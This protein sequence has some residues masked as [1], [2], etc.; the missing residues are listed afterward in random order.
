[1]ILSLPSF[2]ILGLKM[3]RVVV[4][5]VAL[6]IYFTSGCRS[7]SPAQIAGA[8][9][10]SD[11]ACNAGDQ[12]VFGMAW[13]PV[14]FNTLRALDSAS[15]YAQTLVYEGLLKY[16][17]NLNIVPALASSFSIS[18]DG[19]TYKFQLRKGAK[20]SDGTAITI[21]DVKASFDLAASKA[22]P[23]RSDYKCIESFESLA[24]KE[25]NSFILHL[26]YPSAPLLARLVELRILPARIICAKDR[27]N[28][29]L[30]RTPLGS[31][32]FRLLHWQSG[33]ELVFVPNEFYW[34]EK[35][36]MRQLV[37]R[38]VPDKTLLSIALR[39]GEVDVAAIDPLNL[40][41]LLKTAGAN[42]NYQPLVVDQFNGSRTV[43][44]GFN[45]RKLPCSNDGVRLA[46]ARAI[47]RVAMGKVL[48]AG[49]AQIPNSDIAPG[50]WVY[51]A[52]TR[53]TSFNPQLAAVTLQKAGYTLVNRRWCG[54]GSDKHPL[55]F[56]ILTV[57][58][59][60]DVAQAVVDDLSA[61][62]IPAEVQVLEY[63]TLRQQYLRS[64][65]F[66]LFVWSRSSGPDPECSLVW[67]TGGAL[68]FCGFTD[69]DVD[70]LL[71][72]GR[73]QIDRD[74]RKKIYQTIQDILAEKL[75]WVFLAQPKLLIIHKSTVLNIK[76]SDQEI[77]GLP[78]DNPL[79][80]AS[81]WRIKQSAPTAS[82][83]AL[84]ILK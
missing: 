82:V 58:D 4:I 28:A 53:L 30:S 73:R 49:R 12:I 45:L 36:K 3:R 64:G 37:W 60:Q 15:Y 50:N 8:G 14:S 78:W 72:D 18:G 16:D 24:S 75:P 62:N 31:G 13:E 7:I 26:S 42:K 68:N 10:K 25:N 67:G 22:S 70:R 55:S 56:R 54:Q 43:Y 1:M 41:A 19:K 71:A 33:Q 40:Q 39:R 81:S 84:N 46:I 21:A 83:G 74:K 23:F 27:G 69:K 52:N 38:I 48:F 29:A 66:D 20:F 32:P 6:A 2:A 77:T 76:Q 44:L 9:R 63:T 65:D 80:N 59:F 11:T 17:A 57:K 47:N 5:F 34:G 51:N 35:P 61:I 79:F